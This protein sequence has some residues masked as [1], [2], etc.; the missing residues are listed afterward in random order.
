MKMIK[1]FESHKPNDS[2]TLLYYLLTTGDTSILEEYVV[3]QL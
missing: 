2:Q 3:L 1:G